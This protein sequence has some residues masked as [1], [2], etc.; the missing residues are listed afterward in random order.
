MTL[1]VRMILAHVSYFRRRRR[2]HSYYFVLFFLPFLWLCKWMSFKSINIWFACHL[3]QNQKPFANVLFFKAIAHEPWDLVANFTL[4]ER[5][6]LEVKNISGG[7]RQRKSHN[8]HKQFIHLAQHKSVQVYVLKEATG[9]WQQNQ[10]V[11]R[12]PL[13]NCW[14]NISDGRLMGTACHRQDHS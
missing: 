9:V 10:M 5:L 3:H 11:K 4:K 14:S 7:D 6:R 13:V 2:K 8:K 12:S 1:K